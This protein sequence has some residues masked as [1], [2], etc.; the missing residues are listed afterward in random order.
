MDSTFQGYTLKVRRP[1]KRKYL[2]CPRKYDTIVL[3][4]ILFFLQGAKEWSILLDGIPTDVAVMPA[5]I[6]ESTYVIAC[7]RRKEL[8]EGVV[9]IYK[10]TERLH[11]LHIQEPIQT[12][13]YGP[14]GFGEQG[15]IFNTTGRSIYVHRIYNVLTNGFVM[16]MGGG[17]YS[18]SYKK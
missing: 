12:F 8:Q 18:S 15:F 16:I 3:S 13:I 14:Y 9:Y 5:Y 1:R 6:S 4:Y 11:I 10:G 17:A 7:N 2:L